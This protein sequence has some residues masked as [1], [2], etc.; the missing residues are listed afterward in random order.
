M[1][2]RKFASIAALSL[3]AIASFSYADAA[4]AM[5]FTM[6][7]GTTGPNGETNQGAYT[8]D[9]NA[10]TV[11]FNN[12]VD[13]KGKKVDGTA[14]TTGFAQY[15]FNNLTVNPASKVLSNTWAPVGTVDE[16]NTSKYLQVFANSSVTIS[17][18]SLTKSFGLDWGAAHPGNTLSFFK[19]DTLIK[20]FETADIG[21]FAL[22]SE[23]HP[24]PK[25]GDSSIQS[26]PGSNTYYQ[27]NG[28]VQFFADNADEYFNKIVISQKG[29]GGFE[30]DNHSFR[31]V[32]EPSLALGMLAIGGGMLLLKRKNQKALN[33]G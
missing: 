4:H 19:G 10:I 11:D 13:A 26:A 28:Y 31:T 8:K 32:P 27:G 5:S 33:L 7:T 30:S 21:K 22:Y 14:P 3:S 1:F 20:T 24:G 9:K 23:Q 17:L 29:A 16:K 6:S 2:I 15:T 12:T 25:A 18:E